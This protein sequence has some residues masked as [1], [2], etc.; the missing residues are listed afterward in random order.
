[1]ASRHDEFLAAGSRIAA[2]SV[3]SVG[4]QAA[5][6]DMLDLPFPVLSDPDRSGAIAPFGIADPKDPREIAIPAM[7]L[8]D[9]E[10]NEVFRFVSR[11][12]ADRLPED[13]VL[14]Q[15]DELGFGPT[16]Q[17]APT[18][19]AP[20]P[21]ERAMPLDGLPYYLRGARFAIAAF[22]YRHKDL[23]E[24]LKED[25]KAYVEEMDRYLDAVRAL[26]KRFAAG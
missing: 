6:V 7:M 11:D 23:D 15:V 8:V 10:G 22:G 9:P 12:Y 20:E 16:T 24:S 5:I 3:D 13:E 25:S 4:Q 26:R 21:G 17:D 18:P 2:I 14:A 1:M 19:G